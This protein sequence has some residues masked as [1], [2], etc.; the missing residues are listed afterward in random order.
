MI[1]ER[2]I[3]R[4]ILG[5]IRLD[6]G[7]WRIK[8]NQ[9]ISDTL[10]GQNIIG[11]IKKQRLKWLGHV[12]HMAED[13]NVKKIKRW[14]PMSKRPRGRP[15]LRWEDA[16]LE[17]INSMNLCNWRN[18]AQDREWWKKVVEQVKTLNRL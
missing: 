5:P 1:F 18:V 10:K 6:D 16:V 4:K 7:R 2:K 9:E 3:M 15:K 17:D 8:T 11:F 14:Q 12:E 13:N